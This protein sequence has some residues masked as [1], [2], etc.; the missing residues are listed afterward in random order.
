M[1]SGITIGGSEAAAAVG[2]DPYRSQVQLWAEK[3]DKLEPRDAGE[4]A[5]WGT[6]LEPVVR[7][8]VREHGYEVGGVPSPI[9]PHEGPAY[10]TGHLDGIVYREGRDSQT[11][12]YE[13]KTCG[14]YVKG[15]DNGA[16]PPAYIV[17]V[18][19]YMILTGLSWSLL[20]CLVAGQKLELR[21]IERDES[22]VQLILEAEGQFVE[23]CETD[24]PPPPD[25]SEATTEVIKRLYRN[26]TGEIIVLTNDDAIKV[27]ELRK[28]KHSQKLIEQE[29]DR[30]ENELKM[31]L[32]TATAG[33]FNGEKLI[34]WPE[35]VQNVKATEAH[36]RHYRR[37]QVHG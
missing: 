12:V 10:M 17:Q 31:R 7:E 25:G 11:G 27:E 28:V 14:P 16:A 15:W 4:A 30:L 20:A 13:G 35:I 22:L 26:T 24:T 36:E 5:L 32:G 23:W 9:S 34:S 33:V 3:T 37:F 29:R 1:A 8:Q 6:L 2:L 18:H 21:E 19:H